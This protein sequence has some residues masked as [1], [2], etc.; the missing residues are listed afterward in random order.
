MLHPSA[1]KM[2]AQQRLNERRGVA[3]VASAFGVAAGLAHGAAPASDLERLASALGD[4]SGGARVASRDLRWEPSRGVVADAASGRWV[5]YLGRAEGED[6]RDVWRARVRVSPEGRALEVV[7][8]HDLTNTPLGDDHALV[9]RGSHAAFATRAYGR[10]Q[11]VTAVDLSGAGAQDKSEA[12]LDRAMAAVT[13]AQQTGSAAGIGR[14]DVMLDSPADAVSLSLSDAA[15]LEITADGS[16]AARLDLARGDWLGA[17]AGMSV[18]TSV[19]LP[20]RFSHWAVDTLRAVP[21][22]GPAPIA[23]LESKALGVRDT[24]RRISFEASA[25]SADAAV[26][27]PDPPPPPLDTSRAS[28]EQAHWPPPRIATIWQKPEEGEGAWIAPGVPWLHRAPGLASDAPPPM[29]RT[30]LRPDEERPYA[31]VLLVAMD[32]RQLDLDMEAGIEDPEPL[33]GPHG[34]GRI[35]RA[36]AVYKRVVAA[37]NGAFKTEHGH[38]GMMVHKRVLLPPVPGSASVVVLDDGRVGMGSWGGDRKVGGVVGVAD[39]S[40]VSF[41]QNLEALVDRGVVNPTG[42]NLWGFTLPG[43]GVQTERSGLCVTTSG[44][45]LYAWGD[46][47]SATALAKAMKMA[48]CDYAMHLDMNP[49]HTGFLFAA[50]DDLAGKKYRT[51]LLDGGMQ[52]PADRYVNY[53][54]KDFFYV[55]AHDPTPPAVD[56]AA[57]WQADGG[58]QPPPKWMPGVWS[59][60]LDVG[61]RQSDRLDGPRGSVELYD[62]EA[63]RAT[64]RIRAGAKDATA[65]APLRELA[66]DEATRVLFA[67]GMGAASDKRPRGIATDGKLAVATRGGEG[68]A[69][70]VV[71]G[72]GKLSIVRAGDA[73]VAAHDDMAELPLLFWD[74][75]DTASSSG[76]AE[77][78]AALGVTAG[79]RVILARGAF[80]TSAPLAE[81]LARAG[82][83]RAVALDRGVHFGAPFDRAGT[84]SPPLARYDE[85]VL[86][87]IASPLRPRGFR[88]DPATLV[89]QVVKNK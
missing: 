89:A 39:D 42:R 80:S 43:K 75:R 54:P 47:V 79:G 55:M 48:G 33:V 74:G 5:L 78:R 61:G 51:E 56:G 64:W 13:N 73:A 20:K 49:Y 53:A 14:L 59:T 69:A 68:W 19:H 65:A 7:E 84:A 83:T 87:A 22:I 35:P 62:V 86:Y 28:V 60:H 32:M 15:A 72:D 37:F 27:T 11:S 36:P 34:S 2:R 70:I 18:A 57:P 21:W 23:W 26:A 30:F 24:F 50:I 76:A 16:R 8:A 1:V 41:R 31:K 3:L 46:D 9:V 40:I 67:I 45:L 29:M 58:A 52:I 82:C 6:T 12:M 4:A 63:Q 10:V 71:G 25:G 81:A 44:H 88:F 85:S 77:S 66:G 38:Y 17:A